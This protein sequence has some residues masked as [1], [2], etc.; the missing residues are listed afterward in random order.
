MMTLIA[1]AFPKLRS[2]KNVVRKMCKKACF[3][4]SFESQNAKRSPQQLESAQQHFYRNFLS[5]QGKWNW[6]IF[7]SVISEILRLFINISTVD[8]KYSL[9][10]S[11][12]L[13]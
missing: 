7:L 13:Q 12:N 9:H 3:K 2:V 11:E 10:N 6:I 1:D 5:L 4:T 8:D